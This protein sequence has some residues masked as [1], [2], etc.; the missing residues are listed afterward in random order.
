MWYPLKDFTV[1][2]AK[3]FLRSDFARVVKRTKY[4]YVERKP[5]KSIGYGFFE[6]IL[7]CLCWCDFLGALYCGDG[8]GI[9]GGGIGNTKRSKKFIDEILGAVNPEYKNVS[10]DLI[11]VYRHGTVH[12]FAPAGTFEIRLSDKAHHLRIE[13]DRV[14]VSV[15]QLLDDLLVGTKYFAKRLRHVSTV[16][17]PGTLGAFNK[18]RKELG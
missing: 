4:L 18:G 2:E 8:K 6:P 10:R 3:G 1:Q 17:V 11:R 12:A 15:E 14:V 9:S 13:K 5:K 16:L 7:L